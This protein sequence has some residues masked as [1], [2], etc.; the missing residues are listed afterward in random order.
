MYQ[1]L[2]GSHDI[3]KD[4]QIKGQELTQI[5]KFKYLGFT[6]AN[7][8]RLNAELDTRMSNAFKGFN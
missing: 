2:P 7:N 4:M 3:G 6:V 1:L 8:K 5:N